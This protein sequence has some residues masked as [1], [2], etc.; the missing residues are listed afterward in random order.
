MES[1]AVAKRLGVPNCRVSV[2]LSQA[3][4]IQHAKRDGNPNPGES[5]EW[6]KLVREMQPSDQL[7]LIDCLEAR[8]SKSVSDP[9]FYALVRN[10]TI[11]A[12]FH[13]VMID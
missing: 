6:V 8:R 13:S 5:H 1:V 9:Y 4:V 2:P 12:K 3:E 10:D 11:I 7:R